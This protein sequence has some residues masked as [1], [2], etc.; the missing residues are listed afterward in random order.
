MEAIHAETLRLVG[1]KDETWLLLHPVPFVGSHWFQLSAVQPGSP[2]WKKVAIPKWISAETE[3]WYC[4]C[5]RVG[6][7]MAVLPPGYSTCVK[8]G[9][10]ETSAEAV[11][12]GGG[13]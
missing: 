4:S 13:A 9:G 5:C 3:P 6:M 2:S 8:A 10:G 12:P 7:G 11:E 1:L